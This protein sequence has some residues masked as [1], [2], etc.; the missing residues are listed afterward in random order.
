MHLP[1]CHTVVACAHRCSEAASPYF[2]A[3]PKGAREA[4]HNR[5]NLVHLALERSYGGVGGSR[6]N[7]EGVF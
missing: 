4:V 3:L 1:V 7:G 2:R 5:P 6:C